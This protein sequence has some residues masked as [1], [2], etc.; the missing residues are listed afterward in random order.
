VIE[1]EDDPHFELPMDLMVEGISRSLTNVTGGDRFTIWLAA[2][3]DGPPKR[4]VIL[5]AIEWLVNWRAIVA[6][7]QHTAMIPLTQMVAHVPPDFSIV[8]AF[9]HGPLPVG[10]PQDLTDT[11][12]N[13]FFYRIIYFREMEIHRG[14]IDADPTE[15]SVALT[16]FPKKRAKATAWW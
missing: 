13:D 5:G 10:Y 14:E 15:P 8:R 2:T 12:G 4:L 3:R 9:D 7:G 6:A 1:S 11:E 16:K